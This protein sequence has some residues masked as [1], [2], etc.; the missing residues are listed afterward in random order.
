M[1]TNSEQLQR[2]APVLRAFVKEAKEG[3]FG[4]PCSKVGVFIDCC[5]LPQ[6]SRAAHREG[7][8]DRSFKRALESINLFYGHQKT[9][10]LLVDSPLP[11]GHPYTNT[12]SY[13]GRGWCMMEKMA[14]AIGTSRASST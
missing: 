6:R 4:D 8:D 9:F 3:L 12:Q 13:E 2:I 10:V 11:T 14:S 5:A 1:R 7:T